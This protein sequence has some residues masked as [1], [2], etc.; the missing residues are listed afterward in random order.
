VI[1]ELLAE[2]GAAVEIA[3]TQEVEKSFVGPITPELY[4]G[5]MEAKPRGQ[6]LGNK[7]G[8][9]SIVFEYILPGLIPENHITLQGNWEAQPQL[10]SAEQDGA[11]LYLNY[12]ASEV[13]IV[14]ET[15]GEGSAMSVLEDGIPLATSRSGSD[16][17]D[18]QVNVKESRLYNLVNGAYGNHLLALNM[19][20]GI[21]VAAFTFG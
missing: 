11:M 15:E 18:G 8:F 17:I 21:K 6:D 14:L 13:N 7:G 3:L 16:V 10:L 1:Q 5:F 4:A 12:T 19:T 2:K 20:R 9:K